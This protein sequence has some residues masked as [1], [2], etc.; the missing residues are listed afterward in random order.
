[1]ILNPNPP[2]AGAY[3]R[4]LLDNDESMGLPVNKWQVGLGIV[5]TLAIL[6]YIGNLA[7]NALDEA[8][9]EEV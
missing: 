3:S 9:A 4:E 5:V 6:W 8:E 1:L 2:I 7:K